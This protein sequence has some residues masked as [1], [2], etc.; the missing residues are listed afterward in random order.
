[1]SSEN[2]PPASPDPSR[3]RSSFSPGQAFSG[4]FSRSSNAGQS[5]PTNA[6]PG[7]IT[8][9][10]ANATQRRSMSITTLGL[11]TSPTQP[12]PFTNRPM[13]RRSSISSSG[14]PI[15]E[16]AIEEGDAAAPPQNT[17]ATPFGRRLSFGA[18]ALRDVRVGSGSTNGEGLNWGEQLRARARAPSLSSPSTNP[19]TERPMPPQTQKAPSVEAKTPAPRRNAPDHIGEKMLRGD[20]YMD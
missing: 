6:F 20:F 13:N 7:P 19:P 5:P 9:A 4:L 3:R 16:E 14:S 12:S 10:A 11:S 1:M 15:D 18:Q 2:S 8:T 17:P